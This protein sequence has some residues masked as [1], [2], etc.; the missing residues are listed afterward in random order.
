ME[1]KQI[2]KEF[3]EEEYKEFFCWLFDKESIK[4]DKE[5]DTSKCIEYQKPYIYYT[6]E[7]KEFFETKPMRRL[8]RIGQLAN[9]L[10]NNPNSTHTRLD[11][12]KGAY[13]KMLEFYML[14]YQKLEWRTNNSNEEAKLKVLA[15]M[16]DMATHDIG[17]NVC[18]HALEE[19][20]GTG[21]G[22]HEVLGNR[23]LHENEEVVNAFNNIHP[24]LLQSLDIVKQENYNLHS[25]KEGSIDFDRADFLIRDSLYLGV[26]NGVPSVKEYSRTIAQLLDKIMNGCEIYKINRDGKDMRIP[27]FS[28][29][30]EPD[31]EEFLERRVENYENIY[32]SK[33]NRPYDGLLLEYCK[34]LIKSNE[35]NC[36]LKVF[37]EH[38][39]DNKIE[40]IDLNKFLEWDDIRFFN[41][42][43][44][45]AS[46]SKDEDLKNFSKQCLPKLDSLVS[47]VYNRLMPSVSP[48]IDE[49]GNEIE[50]ENEF[51]LQEDRKFYL[52]VRKLVK[53]PSYYS[54]I[55]EKNKSNEVITSMVFDSIDEQEKL[56]KQLEEGI[57]VSETETISLSK[58][59]IDKLD[60]WNYKIKKYNKNE[61]IFIKDRENKI[62]TLDEYPERNLDITPKEQYGIVLIDSKLKEQGFEPSDIEKCKI[63]FNKIKE[64]NVKNVLNTEST[65]LNSELIDLKLKIIEADEK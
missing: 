63:L 4:L 65:R 49:N 46:N 56:K 21:K 62:Y 30:V 17:H 15:D 38:I 50:L 57:A 60:F 35:E 41:S 5:V 16:M 37:L 6:Q 1:E 22:A 61:P 48:K 28:Y 32:C 3:T 53:N 12:C 34:Y 59:V 47:L 14:Q 45:L 18:S 26:E 51:E 54:E 29:E 9:C 13:Q 33:L 27:V 7:I 64:N 36:E 25:L 20:I 11:H 40:D 44:D 52:N 58:D 10:F 2:I 23:I 55:F 43:F 24:K 42:V 39:A 8:G 31:I 19:L